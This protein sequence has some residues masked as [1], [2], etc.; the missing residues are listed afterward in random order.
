MGIVR[1][2]DTIGRAQ[3]ET[4]LAALGE[5]LAA[6]GLHYELVFVGGGNLILRE[7]IPRPMTKDLDV[8]GARTP[9]GVAQVRP[10]PEPLRDAVMDVGR[11]FGLADDWLNTG[12]DSLLDLGLPDGF[13]ERLERRD[14]GGLVAWLAGRFDMVCFKLYAAADQGLRSRHFQDLRDLGPAR[15]DLLVAGRWAVSHD[16]SPGF[17]S[18]LVETLRALSVED[19]D[20]ALG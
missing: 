20:A 6:R 18:L 19:A 3:L 8:L 11:A 7:L 1:G 12:P 2:M 14:Y 13:V 15:D 4:A 9:D 16:T 10:M 5:L 17:R